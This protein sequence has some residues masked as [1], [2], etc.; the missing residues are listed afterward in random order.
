MHVRKHVTATHTPP[1]SVGR[2]LL[3][4]QTGWS[5]RRLRGS[6]VP[7]STR[8]H[9]PRHKDT[10]TS[11]PDT[12]TI[13]NVS[14]FLPTSTS[15][16]HWQNSCFGSVGWLQGATRGTIQGPPGNPK[17]AA[18]FNLPECRTT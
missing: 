2:G 14:G 8:G 12:S 9:S 10:T 1:S 3:P 17:R 4:S 18:P 6:V 15:C 13:V 5:Q 7:R 11:A 16:S